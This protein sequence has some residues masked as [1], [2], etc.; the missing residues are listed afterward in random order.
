MTLTS[1]ILG[2]KAL[3]NLK[4]L[5]A[6]P[7]LWPGLIQALAFFSVGPTLAWGLE[8][9]PYLIQLQFELA[10]WQ[11]SIECKFFEAG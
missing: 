6:F 4:N 11:F 5:L 9:E 8:P 1:E 7:K 2:I 3:Q 10:G